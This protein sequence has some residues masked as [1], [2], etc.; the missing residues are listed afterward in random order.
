MEKQIE[1]IK[2]YGM[3]A[4]TVALSFLAVFLLAKSINE[5]KL[6]DSIGDN[7]SP[8]NVITVSGKGEMYAVPDVATFTFTIQK[9]DKTV[10]L[11]QTKNTDIVNKATALLKD[12]GVD[13]KD[14]QTTDYSVSPK[15]EYSQNVCT[16]NYCPPTK[17]PIIVGYYVSQTTTV[18]V[19]D[20]SKAGEILTAIGSVGANSVSGLSFI[21]D[22]Q[23]EIQR[24]ARALAIT[25]A[26]EQAQKLASDLGVRLGKLVSFNEQANYPYPIYAKTLSMDSVGGGAPAVAPEIS[27]GQNKIVSNVSL[28]YEIK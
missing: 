24:E 7:I 6:T 3:I 12:K 21:V 19:R 25:D 10:S 23:D 20:V 11:A 14:I 17:D 5:F 26:K 28:T 27:V 22:N 4:G 2:K 13:A 8:S 15:Y 18:K 1:M 16:V 9:D